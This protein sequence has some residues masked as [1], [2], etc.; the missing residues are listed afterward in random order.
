MKNLSLPNSD[1]YADY[2]DI[3]HGLPDGSTPIVLGLA[4]N[5]NRSWQK[6]NS[7]LVIRQLKGR[8]EVFHKKVVS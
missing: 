8:N 1:A 4:A 2:L 5:V 3:I 7:G 6:L